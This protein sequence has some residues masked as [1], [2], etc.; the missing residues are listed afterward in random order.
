M[1]DRVADRVTDTP[2]Y[3]DYDGI[4]QAVSQFRRRD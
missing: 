1:A 2:I 3:L 4:R